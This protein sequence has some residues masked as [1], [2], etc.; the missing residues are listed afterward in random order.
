MK[1]STSEA[2]RPAT[3]MRSRSSEV[4]RTTG[5]RLIMLEFRAQIFRRFRKVPPAK[6]GAEG[7][8]DH[9]LPGEASVGDDASNAGGGRP[10]RTPDPLLEPEDGAVH[11]RPP[12]QDP[13]QP[14]RKHTR[15]AAGTGGR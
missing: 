6:E 15:T 2:R 14:P 1:S 8:A 11:L 5:I 7:A 9:P 13:P 10:F 12:Q 3:R 4:F